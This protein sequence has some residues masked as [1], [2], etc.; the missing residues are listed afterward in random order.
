MILSDALKKAIAEAQARRQKGQSQQQKSRM[1]VKPY[2][3]K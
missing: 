1:T 2:K 3:A